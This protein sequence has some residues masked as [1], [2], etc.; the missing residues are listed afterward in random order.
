MHSAC[1]MCAAPSRDGPKLKNPHHGTQCL[2]GEGLNQEVGNKL[3]AQPLNV[4]EDCCQPRACCLLPLVPP[5]GPLIPEG[6][7]VAFTWILRGAS[8]RIRTKLGGAHKV[9]VLKPIGIKPRPCAGT[10]LPSQ[11]CI[12]KE[13][14]TLYLFRLHCMHP[15]TGQHS[16]NPVAMTWKLHPPP[17]TL[18]FKTSPEPHLA[19]ALTLAVMHLTNACTSRTPWGL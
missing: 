12:T 6:R 1:K 16:V 10:D 13:S 5:L 17:S 4:F 18:S 15:Q 3:C 7:P 14:F 19:L 9:H 2:L 11:Q 8:H